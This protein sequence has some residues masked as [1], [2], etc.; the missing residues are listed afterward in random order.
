M[1]STE[2]EKTAVFEH[3]FWL[4]VLGDHARFLYYAF[5]A[6]ER[7][8]WQQ[9]Q[10]FIQSFDQLLQDV[11]SSGSDASRLNQITQSAYQQARDLRQFKLTILRRQL[12]G[13]LKIHLTPTFVNHMVNEVDE[14]LRILGYLLK[15]QVP[16]LAHPIHHHLLWLLDAS[17]HSGAIEASMDLTESQLKQRSHQFTSV[18]QD[19]YLKAV[20]MAGYLRANLDRFPALSR[21]NNDVKLEMLVFQKFLKELEEMELQNTDL[22]TFSPLMADHMYREECYYLMKLAEVT[23]LSPPDCNP[24]EPRVQPAKTKK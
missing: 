2:W 1:N 24:A 4:Q 11:R 10:I 15:Q 8:Y 17:G 12:V 21:F 6:N 19:F 23:E 5:P 3:S 18:F 7:A 14:Y 13:S 20:E 9:A 22:S 16:P